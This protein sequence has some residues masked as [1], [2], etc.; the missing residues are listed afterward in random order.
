MKNIFKLMGVAL[1][2]SSML[3]VSCNKTEEE[4][5]NT[6]VTPTETTYTVKV[7]CNDN[8]MGTVT[9]SPVKEKYN[10]GDEI[11]ITATPNDGFK[12]VNWNDTILTASYTCKVNANMTFTAT[13]AALP[14][15]SY[16]VVFDGTA[17]DVAGYCH[18]E[19][20]AAYG[21]YRVQFAKQVNGNNVYFPYLDSYYEG[22]TA[23]D[24]ELSSYTELYHET[25][26]NDGQYNYGDWQWFATN[27]FN[28]TGLDL[29]DNLLSCTFSAEMFSYAE[30]FNDE[31]EPANCTKKT[32]AVT[33]ANV[34]FE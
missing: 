4:E 15:T 27:N 17:L 9:V 1:I 22:E 20:M 8:T 3:F 26:F 29:T 2:T 30:Y 16:T 7:T 28:C 10:A 5:T 33:F 12:F 21:Y 13:F 14:Q 18:G 6:N 24:L 23:D 25:Y 31:T 32:L 34:M 11:T 19:Y